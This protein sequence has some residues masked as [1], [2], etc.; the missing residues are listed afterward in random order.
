MIFN[1]LQHNGNRYTLPLILFIGNEEEECNTLACTEKTNSADN[2]ELD[3][4]E[5]EI[6]SLLHDPVPKYKLRSDYLNL[7]GSYTNFS[8]DQAGDFIIKTP[9]L[10]T[11]QESQIKGSLTPEQAGAAL[12]Y[13]VLSGNRLSQMTQT[14][15]DVDAVTRLLQVI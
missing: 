4:T 7:H 8:E 10:S 14:Y 11:E 15:K 3:Q 12:E 13:F 2:E 6:V 1:L 5:V 9:T